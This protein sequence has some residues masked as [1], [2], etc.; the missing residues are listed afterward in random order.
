MTLLRRRQRDMAPRGTFFVE[1]ILR[2]EP[3]EQLPEDLAADG[4]SFLDVKEQAAVVQN[5]NHVLPGVS[6]PADSFVERRVEVR[7]EF[8]RLRVVPRSKNAGAVQ[9]NGLEASVKPTDAENLFGHAR[10]GRRR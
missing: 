8:H 6:R 4:R 10:S 3:F 5:H 7:V 9:R 1:T 2:D